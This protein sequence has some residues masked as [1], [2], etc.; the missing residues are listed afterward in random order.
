MELSINVSIGSPFGIGR[1]RQGRP[2]PFGTDRRRRGHI[3]RVRA[4]KN[5]MGNIVHR[6]GNIVR[7]TAVGRVTMEVWTA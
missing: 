1:H 4:K 2:S 5:R 3:E 6:M 7:E